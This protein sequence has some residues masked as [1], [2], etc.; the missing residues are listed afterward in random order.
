MTEDGSS[1][2]KKTLTHAFSSGSLNGRLSPL[3]PS[4]ELARALSPADAELYKA[5][6]NGNYSFGIGA[7]AYFRRVEFC[8]EASTGPVAQPSRSVATI[9]SRRGARDSTAA[10]SALIAR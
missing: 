2:G 1:S 8:H 9:A 6:I 10:A 3:Q 4:K 5:L 7:L